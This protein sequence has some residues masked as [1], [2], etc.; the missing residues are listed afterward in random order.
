MAIKFTN[1]IAWILN[2]QE[3]RDAVCLRYGWK[4]KDTPNYCA[5]GEKNDVCHTLNCKKGGFVTMRHN[6]IR[7]VEANI[8]REV[9]KDV[10]TE[11][12]LQPVGD[13]QL[14]A[15]SNKTNQARLDVSAVGVWS[16]FE[17]TFL[18]IR[19]TNPGAAS[20]S[21]KSVA[22]LLQLNEQEKIKKYNDRVL[23]VEKASFVPMVFT[24]NGG[25][26]LQ[27]ERLNKRLAELISERRKESYSHVMGHIR[28]RLRFAL[29]KSILIAIRGVRGKQSR[30]V[31]L[32]VSEI[33]FGM[34]QMDE[35]YES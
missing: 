1:Q 19:V 22:K 4:I 16:S 33:E 27:C 11:P 24:T 6:A 26:S 7:D 21:D 18:D 32:K 30:T 23:Q 15:G 12:M 10:K 29:L 8:L 28:T 3:F 13:V 2:K 35:C 14:A 5:C 25:M 9:C 34:V 31:E 17:R 20:N